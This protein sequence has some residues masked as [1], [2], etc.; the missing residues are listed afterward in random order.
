MIEEGLP[1][2]S[3]SIEGSVTYSTPDFISSEISENFD[4]V[5]SPETLAEVETRGRPRRLTRT[6]Q[7]SDIGIRIPTVP[8]S[9]TVL[10]AKQFLSTGGR[11]P[12]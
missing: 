9:A 1:V 7:K 5:F 2:D 12:S 3:Q 11:A 10:K 6:L 8:S 4:G